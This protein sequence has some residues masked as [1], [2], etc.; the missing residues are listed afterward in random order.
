ML[1]LFKENLFVIPKNEVCCMKF[2]ILFLIIMLSVLLVVAGCGVTPGKSI[3][4]QAVGRGGSS[5]G[6]SVVGEGKISRYS[7]VNDIGVDSIEMDNSRMSKVTKLTPKVAEECDNGKDDDSDG[8]V[9]CQDAECSSSTDCGPIELDACNPNYVWEEGAT[10]RLVN[11]INSNGDC[12][13]MNQKDV[14]LDCNGYMITWLK[15]KDA[16]KNL[17]KVGILITEPGVTVQN[18]GI[19]NYHW[20]IRTLVKGGGVIIEGNKISEVS[21]IGILLAA[22]YAFVTNNIITGSN[23]GIIP[24]KFSSIDGAIILAFNGNYIFQGN[25][26]CGN[27]KDFHCFDGIPSGKGNTFGKVKQC[28]NDWPQMPK[29]YNKCPKN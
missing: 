14:T 15:S 27:S 7:E 12:F 1:K 3:A 24:E 8:K 17:N 18:C 19:T 9:D 2:K 6:L 29:H 22:D 21:S 20:G 23:I 25:N 10:Y 26:V 11:D 5:E 16:D 28:S 13:N 4:G